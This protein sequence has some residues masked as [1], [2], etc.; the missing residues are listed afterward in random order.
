MLHKSPASRDKLAKAELECIGLGDPSESLRRRA[1]SDLFGIATIYVVFLL[2]SLALDLGD[3]FQDLMARH[4]KWQLDEFVLAGVLSLVAFAGFSWRQWIRYSGEINRRL[5]LE[6]ELVELRLLADRFGENKALFLSNLA[7]DFR[8]PL[9][10]ILGFAQLLHEEP[11]GP[12]GND[13]YKTYIATIRE[14]AIML[15]DRIATCLDPEKIDFGAEPMQ[16]MPF[17]LKKAVAKAVP[18]VQAMAQSADVTVEDH[19]P[20]N[21]PDIHGD[22]RAIRKA[23]INLVTNAIKHCRHGGKIR[24][25]AAITPYGDLAMEIGDNGVGVDAT[26]IAAVKRYEP[27]TSKAEIVTDSQ[28]AGLFIVKKLLHLHDASLVIENR[29]GHGTVVTV[30]FPKGRLISWKE[31]NGRD[32]RDKAAPLR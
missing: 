5:K 31:A 28:G 15:N 22:R 1:F 3:H 12:I 8:T 7:H 30:T 16:M 4:E 19:I 27:E 10:G 2:V 17:P 24:L 13:H 6:R 14:S 25:S 9:N 29:L 23:V 21:L 32:R 18:V 11:F 26:V 20:E